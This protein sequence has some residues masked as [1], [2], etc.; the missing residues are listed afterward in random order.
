M[1][2]T[3]RRVDYY[4]A[5][6][7]HRPGQGAAILNAFKDAKVNF[8]ALHA[9]PEGGAAQLDFFPH[10]STAFEEAAKDAGIAVS[11]RKTAFLIQG[12]DRVGAIAEILGELGDAGVNV[13]AL[14]AVTADGGFGAVLWV[15]SEQVETAAR[16]L[17]AASG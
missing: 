8:L 5:T 15:E 17:G 1:S 16:A 6:V 14:D 11:P 13:T 9:F 3:I 4:Y 7:P 10:D 12:R 2:D